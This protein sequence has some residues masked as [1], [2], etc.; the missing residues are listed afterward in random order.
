MEKKKTI[1]IFVKREERF[2]LELRT[3]KQEEA[4]K[5]IEELK[6]EDAQPTT[7]QIHET[8]EIYESWFFIA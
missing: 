1:D 8:W 4:D 6:A 7:H 2:S 5:K 3:T